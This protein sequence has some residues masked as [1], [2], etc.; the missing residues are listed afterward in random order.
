MKIKIFTLLIINYLLINCSF[1][2]S[3]ESNIPIIVVGFSK[4]EQKIISGLEENI[5][6]YA[7][8]PVEKR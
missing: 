4:G 3:A 6:Y 7:D 5:N 8:M 2:F 1:I